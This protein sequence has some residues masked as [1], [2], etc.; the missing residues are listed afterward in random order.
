MCPRRT[1][2]RPRTATRRPARVASSRVCV[3]VCVC[4]VFARL[5]VCS[6]RVRIASTVCLSVCVSIYTYM[7]T[8]A[9]YSVLPRNFA[10][11]RHYTGIHTGACKNPQTHTHTH[12]PEI[13]ENLDTAQEAAAVQ[14]MACFA[15]RVFLTY[16]LYVKIK[17]KSTFV[18]KHGP[19]E[20]NETTFEVARFIVFQ[21]WHFSW[22]SLR[23][24]KSDFRENRDK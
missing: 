9:L 12:R 16:F 7:Y 18:L 5:L 8:P 10:A 22:K 13:K 4:A 20:S 15:P 24:S 6:S 11:F 14:K 3:C 1:R 2:P 17:S 19:S 23:E 21:L